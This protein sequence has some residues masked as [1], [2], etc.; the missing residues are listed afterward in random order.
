[1]DKFE[2]YKLFGE[3]TLY[4]SQRRQNSSQIYLT[5]NTA[6]FGIMA[7]LI[8]DSGIH[9]WSLVLANL[10]L[11]VVG[12]LAC[13]VWLTIIVRFKKLIGWY[14]EQL[15]EMEKG[16]KGSY[17]FYTKEWTS[18]LQKSKTGFSD[19][20]AFM[21]KIFI[22]LYLVYVLGMILAVNFGLL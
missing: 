17:K 3:R 5:V 15:R 4:H 7:L 21:P 20:E 22:G 18:F 19:L 2:E 14:Y 16:I 9:G 12:L 1:M 13:T 10:P 6:I 8:K 11:F